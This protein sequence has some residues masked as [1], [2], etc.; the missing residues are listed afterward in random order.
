MTPKLFSRLG[1]M[2]E[3]PL[4]KKSVPE[5]WK[6]GKEEKKNEDNSRIAQLNA[7][8]RTKVRKRR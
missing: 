7:L 5:P 8:E 6:L 4:R 2:A 1:N 3:E